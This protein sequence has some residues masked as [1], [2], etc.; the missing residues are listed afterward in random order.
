ME[1][2]HSTATLQPEEKGSYNENYT[3][4]SD[5]GETCHM[6]NN[7][8]LKYNYSFSG[9]KKKKALKQIKVMG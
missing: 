8:Y 3:L 1:D 6:F 5:V 7:I 2:I 4:Q 9:D